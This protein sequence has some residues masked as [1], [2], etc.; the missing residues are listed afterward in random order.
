MTTHRLLSPTGEFSVVLPGTWAAIP[1]GSDEAMRARVASVVKKQMPNNDRLARARKIV[2]DDLLRSA[3]EAAALGATIFA[4]ALEMLPGVP[5][6]ASL[7]AFA[8]EWPPGV[9]EGHD[10]VRG[11][12]R[13]ALPGGEIVDAEFS[14]VIRRSALEQRREGT[15]EFP[16]LNLEYWFAT[17]NKRLLSFLVS[18]PM[19]ESVELFTA[20][21]DAVAESVRWATPIAMGTPERFA[22]DL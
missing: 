8:Q 2:R 19:C 22:A 11:R 15:V 1:M 17:P 3:G 6:P 13:R 4:L 5:F 20:F 21:F 9:D 12:L 14:V 16:L 7:V 10:G 18:V